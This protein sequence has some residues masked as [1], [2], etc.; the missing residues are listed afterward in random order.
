MARGS[1]K[2]KR[3]ADTGLDDWLMTYADMITLLLC[4]F[5]II[6]TLSMP[7]GAEFQDLQHI[8]Q[9]RFA[10]GDGI[11]AGGKGYATHD[12]GTERT[13]GNFQ[14][15]GIF[16]MPAAVTL[17]EEEEPSKTEP[18]AEEPKLETPAIELPTKRLFYTGSADLKAEAY[19][20]LDAA[21]TKVQNPVFQDHTVVVEGHTDELAADETRY[22]SPW[23]LSAAQASAVARHLMNGGVD[24]HRIKV[25]SLGDT[26]P[27]SGA[28]AR[29]IVIRFEK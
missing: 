21:K 28:S 4:F 13:E 7:K 17:A 19:F 8:M 27:D 23:E 1:F 11:L 2:R 9:K 14:A 12:E 25:V 6:L 24:A 10:G 29:R 15:N 16:V 22:P 26:Q 5:A 20:E 3:R 18:V